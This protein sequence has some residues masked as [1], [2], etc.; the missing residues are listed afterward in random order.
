MNI[1]TRYNINKT[2]S[3]TITSDHTEL[4]R[5]ET[6]EVMGIL[7]RKHRLIRYLLGIKNRRQHKNMM[8]RY[9]KNG[10]SVSFCRK[11]KL[12]DEYIKIGRHIRELMSSLS[13]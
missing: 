4:S 8:Q 11:P 12:L 9:N 6:V 1:H 2:S 3:L 5:T 10:R 13:K 7:E